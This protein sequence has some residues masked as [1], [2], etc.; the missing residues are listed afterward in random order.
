MDEQK[1]ARLEAKGWKRTS[2]KEFLNLSDEE[3]Q[4]IELRLALSKVFKEERKKR[5]MT[6]EA[7]AK[8]VGSSQSR[9]AKMEAGDSSVALDLLFK[10]LFSIGLNAKNL[11]ETVV[12]EL[13][14][15]KHA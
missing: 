12:S 6:Q 14:E 4:T 5:K 7:F 8:A 3:E 10:G 1:R 15:A 13:S 2:V 11:L 9:V